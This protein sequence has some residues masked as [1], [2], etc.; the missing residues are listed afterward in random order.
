ME[1]LSGLP[2][3]STYVS[4]MM[5]NRQMPMRADKESSR[6]DELAVVIT[7]WYG[8]RIKHEHPVPLLTLVLLT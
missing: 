3:E 1:V 7:P 8:S 2:Y 6:F 4:S 5:L